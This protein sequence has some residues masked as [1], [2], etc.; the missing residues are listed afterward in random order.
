MYDDLPPD[1]HRSLLDQ[2]SDGVYF[3]DRQRRITYWNRGAERLTGYAAHE[4]VGRRCKD[5]ILMHCDD[6][7]EVLCGARCPLLD[8]MR[9]ERPREC[10][11]FL[12]HRVLIGIAL[13][14]V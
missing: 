8:A 11:V 6:R 14:L 5:G 7:G 9:D 2:L 13:F 3:V 1:F 10:H 12:H 4:V